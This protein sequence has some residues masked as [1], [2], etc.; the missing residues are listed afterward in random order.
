MFV[1]RLGKAYAFLQQ[2]E[3]ILG[4]SGCWWRVG[5]CS[6]KAP[7]TSTHHQATAL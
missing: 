7:N 6:V 1:N 5:V 2:A 4:Y 3:R